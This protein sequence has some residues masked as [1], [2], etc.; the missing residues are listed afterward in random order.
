MSEQN[1]L[2]K[3]GCESTG[4]EK[5]GEQVEGGRKRQR[6]EGGKCSLGGEGKR[7]QERF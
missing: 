7:K 5:A 2:L 6:K 1:Y 3:G 4:K